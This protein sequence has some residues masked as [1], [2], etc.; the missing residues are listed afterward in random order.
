[1]D[2][3][4]SLLCKDNCYSIGIRKRNNKQG[5]LFEGNY[6]QFHIIPTTSNTWYADPI[7]FTKDNTDY[8]F[9][10]VFDRKTDL[11][12]IGFTVLDSEKPKKPEVVM[13]IGTHLSYPCVFE[14][15][16]VIYMI[17]E[18]TTK[19]TVELYKA[20]NFPYEWEFCELLLS[21]N[22]YAD[23]TVYVSDSLKILL[24]FEQYEGNG[25]KTKVH[26]YSADQILQGKLKNYPSQEFD[27]NYFSRGGGKLFKINNIL[28]RPAQIC[29][30][31]Y[32]YALRFMKVCLDNGLYQEEK[33]CD[34]EPDKL[35]TDFNKKIIGI[36]TY[37]ISDKYEVID[38]KFDD[39]RLKYQVRR[40]FRFIKRKIFKR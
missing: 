15:D 29:K 34:I 3:I 20:R 13:S 2:K 9:C 24:T 40:V 11:G 39:P 5:L 6:A 38:I 8:L 14:L 26:V 31:E 16:G 7:I 21:K 18:T 30:P 33:M 35:N 36:H 12:H 22:E 17:P 25:S 32:G 27:F 19:K 10:E 23:T 37:A 1:M 28:Y 4:K